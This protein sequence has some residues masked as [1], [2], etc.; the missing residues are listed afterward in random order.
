MRARKSHY[1]TQNQ[2]IKTHIILLTT[3]KALG[4]TATLKLTNDV[5]HFD[6]ILF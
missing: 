1:C 3:D 5:P 2:N 6:I 4:H